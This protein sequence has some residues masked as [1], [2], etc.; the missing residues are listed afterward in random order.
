ML[1]YYESGFSSDRSSTSGNPPTQLKEKSM[2]NTI[3]VVVLAL[4]FATTTVAAQDIT[5]FETIYVDGSDRV[6]VKCKEPVE[7]F[8]M[9]TLDRCQSVRKTLHEIGFKYD[10]TATAI[11]WKLAQQDKTRATCD[12]LFQPASQQPVSGMKRVVN[13]VYCLSGDPKRAAAL[14]TRLDAVV[15]K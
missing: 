3:F 9:A 15:H 4:G 10:E 5:P 1:S 2:K 14:K 11:D 12:V 7:G 13:P 8:L 6:S